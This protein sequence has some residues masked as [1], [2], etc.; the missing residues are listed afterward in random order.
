MK[1]F[2]WIVKFVIFPLTPFFIGAIVRILNSGDI[3]VQVLSPTELAFSMAMLSLFISVN[4]S[5]ISN[6]T[7]RDAL[8]RMYQLGVVVFL[9]LFSWAIFL[10][11]DMLI[12]LNSAL[13]V[14]EQKINMGAT[15]TVGDLPKR[16]H[17]F[18]LIFSRLRWMTIVLSMA[19]VPLAIYSNKKYDL[20]DL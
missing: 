5:R 17:H 19:V 6:P 15:I 7:L 10:E 9:A 12:S 1:T 14:I 3:N 2:A 20:E 18:E 4:A 11:T 16:L 8:I 13:V